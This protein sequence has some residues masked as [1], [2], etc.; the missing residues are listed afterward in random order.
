MFEDLQRI[1]IRKKWITEE[2][3]TKDKKDSNEKQEQ[4]EG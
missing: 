1:L 3:V 2:N 4:K